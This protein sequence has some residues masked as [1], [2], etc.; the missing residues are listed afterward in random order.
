MNVNGPNLKRF[1]YFFFFEDNVGDDDRWQ[2]TEKSNV[3]D[4]DDGQIDHVVF[5]RSSLSGKR[6][7]CCMCKC[8]VFCVPESSAQCEYQMESTQ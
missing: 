7:M 8:M 4:D 2:T 5:E 1:I 3:D 6:S